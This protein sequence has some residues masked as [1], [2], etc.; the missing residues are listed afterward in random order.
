MSAKHL[1]AIA[2][3]LAVLLLAWGATELFSR[4]SDTVTGALALP[5]LAQGD[6]DTVTIV[7]G[8]DTVRLVKRSA[9]AWTVNGFPASLQAVGDLFEAL[10]D[11]TPPELVAQ[12]RSSFERMGVDT[13]GGRVVRFARAGKTLAQLLVGRQ[14][15]EFNSGYVRKPGEDNVYLWRNRVTSLVNRG[16]DDWRDRKIAAVAPDSVVVVEIA[17]GKSRYALHRSGHVWAFTGGAP[18]DSGAVARLLEKY[19]SVTAGGFATP[20]QA[21]SVNAARPTRRVTL[22]GARGTALLAL[23]FDSTAGGYWVR[24][25][26]GGTVYRMDPWD[27]EQ[28]TPQ[29][30]TLA[31]LHPQAKKVEPK[32]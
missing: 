17:R 1:K 30:R 5:A 13:A 10:R 18:A 22:R 9:T 25:A 7:H 8:R 27:V 2:I 31:R 6:V 21:D 26:G 11:T 28:L 24:Q 3:A 16:V 14:G 23:V 12:S 15:Q 19:R 4:G 29:E 20:H 32:K